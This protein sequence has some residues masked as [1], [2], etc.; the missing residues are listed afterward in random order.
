MLNKEL[1]QIE[2]LNTLAEVNSVLKDLNRQKQP[3]VNPEQIKKLSNQIEK[4]LKIGNLQTERVVIDVRDC[5]NAY[6]MLMMTDKSNGKVY[7]VCGEEVN[8]MQ[9]YTNCLIEASSFHYEEIEQK[10]KEGS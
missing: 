5:V 2:D 1:S 10:I 7:N 6:Y 3:L 4:T 8:K 9:Y